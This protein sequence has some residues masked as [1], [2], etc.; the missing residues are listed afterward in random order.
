MS[1]QAKHTP[2]PWK[3]EEWKIGQGQEP[4]TEMVL[5]NN[6]HQIGRLVWSDAADKPWDI[7]KS[8]QEAN[9][10]LI[11]AAPELLQALRRLVHPMADDTDVQ[12]AFAAIYQA[13]GEN[14]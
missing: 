12:N 13:T 14:E 11:A 10:R 9:A 6:V 2:A 8:E 4:R 5:H 7:S 3:T 1:E